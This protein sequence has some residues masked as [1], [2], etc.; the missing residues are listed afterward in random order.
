VIEVRKWRSVLP[1]KIRR[2]RSEERLY[3]RS[4]QA[5][6]SEGSSPSGYG[7]VRSR[8]AAIRLVAPHL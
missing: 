4:E 6:N 5:E 7:T 3:P 8:D 2:L 1:Q